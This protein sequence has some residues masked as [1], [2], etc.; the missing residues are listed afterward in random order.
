[1]RSAFV[2][3]AL[4]AGV[5]AKP[6]VVVS[7]PEAPP[8]T[9]NVDMHK[10][11]DYVT[12]VDVVTTVITVTAGQALPTSSVAASSE[13][14]SWAWGGWSSSAAASSAPAATSLV[15]VSS[16]APATSATPVSSVAASSAVEVASS[17]APASSAAASSAAG[18]ATVSAASS[19][20]TY[21]ANVLNHHNVHRANH[22]ASDVT[23]DDTLASTAL[24]IA[25]SC[26]YAHNT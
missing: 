10:E 15:V 12:E 18:S 2:T 6:I 5:L 16:A 21:N 4:A 1:M 26:M 19:T 17:S 22:S 20:N 8:S 24:E 9:P 13:A 23:W 25:N 7:S 11:R 3:A 14:R